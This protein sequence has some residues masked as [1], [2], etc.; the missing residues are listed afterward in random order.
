M[1]LGPRH[2][3]QSQLQGK[4]L[5]SEMQEEMGPSLW[6]VSV[7]RARGHGCILVLKYKC[8]CGSPVS[9]LSVSG[10]EPIAELGADVTSIGAACS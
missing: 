8:V 2:Q 3:A 5:V 7:P 6:F 1:V 10:A 4:C 9:P